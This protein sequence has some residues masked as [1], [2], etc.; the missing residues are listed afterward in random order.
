M[1]TRKIIIFAK[2][3]RSDIFFEKE[4]NLDR[5]EIELFNQGKFFF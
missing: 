3:V 1:H 4:R 5:I 2:T